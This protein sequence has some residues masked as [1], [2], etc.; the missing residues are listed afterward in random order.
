VIGGLRGKVASKEPGRLLV[1]VGG[2]LYEVQVSLQAFSRLPKE[3]AAVAIDVVT[4]VR[5]DA[6]V[7]YGF[8]E[9]VEKLL[10]GW[11]RSVNGVGPKLAQNVLSGIP[12]EDL[13]GALGAGDVPRLC[14]IPGVGKKLAER[15]VLELK[16]RCGE[17]AGSPAGGAGLPAA[18]DEA[19]SALVNLGY[20]RSEAERVVESLP[21]DLSLE[22]AIREA[23][24]RFA[25]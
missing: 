23:L 24:R 21:P 19:L 3:G 15:L 18:G 22:E 14:K 9:P 8:V 5:D 16:E 13:R 20:K 25:R 7:L 11:L 1:D 2:V 12:A 4:H 17:P 10:F 6:I